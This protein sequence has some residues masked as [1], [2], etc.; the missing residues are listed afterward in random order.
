MIAHAFGQLARVPGVIAARVGITLA[1]MHV[2]EVS[3]N[4]GRWINAM[5]EIN[6]HDDEAAGAWC[7]HF[8]WFCW[9]VAALVV[10]CR[11]VSR[12]SGSVVS[13]WHKATDAERVEGTPRP[14]DI[15]LRVR[16]VSD[17]AG[18]LAGGWAYGHAMI[19]VRVHAD[20]AIDIVHG[21]TDGSGGAEGDGVYYERRAYRM[22]DPRLI[23]FIRPTLERV[24]G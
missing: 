12:T 18:V 21:N 14:G 15:A 24:T 1:R 23:G 2:R 17:L 10:G 13:S 5:A 4:R 8:A 16:D 9:Q 19:V 3:A 22:D 11:V 20:G 7:A 6:G